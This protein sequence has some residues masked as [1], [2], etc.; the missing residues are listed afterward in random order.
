MLASFGL[1]AQTNLKKLKKVAVD[2]NKATLL[3]VRNGED[4]TGNESYIYKLDNDV[5]Q[6]VALLY[7]DS[8]D[9]KAASNFY[10]LNMIRQ[11]LTEY[12]RNGFGIDSTSAL[13]ME[14]T[15]NRQI[16]YMLSRKPAL[17]AEEIQE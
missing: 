7:P 14:A 3:I 8:P 10:N 9:R 12:S 17:A 16:M 1:Q 11:V 5:K 4:C 6:K 13:N 15:C 2:T